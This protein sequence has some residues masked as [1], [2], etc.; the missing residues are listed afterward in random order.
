[1]TFLIKKSSKLTRNY[2]P[3]KKYQIDSKKFEDKEERKE[4]NEEDSMN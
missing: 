4:K 3:R 1:M 2:K